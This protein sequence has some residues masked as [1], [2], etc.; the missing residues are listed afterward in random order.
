MSCLVVKTQW[1]IGLLRPAGSMVSIGELQSCLCAGADG[2][3]G[4][5]G[6]AGKP[7]PSG[8]TR[9]TGEPGPKEAMEPAGNIYREMGP[10]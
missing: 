3:I 7:E 10:L 9:P 5:K 1:P 6:Q 2:P 4:E 8:E